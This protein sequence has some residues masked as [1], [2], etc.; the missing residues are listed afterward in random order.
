VD[1]LAARF[2]EAKDDF[3]LLD[4]DPGADVSS[5]GVADAVLEYLGEGRRC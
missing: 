3:E 2:G 1:L 5:P 4:A